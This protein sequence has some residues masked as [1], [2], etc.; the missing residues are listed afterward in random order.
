M[1]FKRRVWEVVEVAKEGDRLSRAFDTFILGLIFLNITAV[2]LETVEWLY[3]LSATFFRAFEWGSV[4]VFTVEYAARGWSCTVDSR[5]AHSVF[6]RLRFVA[7]PLML[8]DLVAIAPFYLASYG[9]LRVVRVL[10]LFRLFRVLKVARYSRAVKT[11]GAVFNAKREELLVAVF[12]LLMLL[13]L[14]SSLIYCTEHEAQPD[15]FAS[16]PDA[17]WWAV[18]TLTTIGYGDV[19]PVTTWGKIVASIIA[20]LGIALFALPAGILASG[21][22]E[23]LQSKKR[24]VCPHCGKEL[25]GELDEGGR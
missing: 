5:Y 10:R 4:L 20:V 16:I 19:H 23:E 24:T 1:A 18:A 13:V 6:G 7:R 15:N 21:F 3:A 11:L 2:I 17:M 22:L 9:S 14:S 8:I 12:V 25:G